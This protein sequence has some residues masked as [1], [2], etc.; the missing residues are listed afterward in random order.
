[1]MEP[2]ILWVIDV[3]KEIGKI[4][5]RTFSAFWLRSSVVSVLNCVNAVTVPIGHLTIH[6]NFLWVDLSLSM[7]VDGSAVAVGLHQTSE[8]LTLF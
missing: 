4:K 7:S 5:M 2:L 6:S 8:Q 3:I 1:M